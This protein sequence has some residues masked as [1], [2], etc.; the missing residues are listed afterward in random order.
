MVDKVPQPPRLTGDN[1]KDIVAIIDWLTAFAM[2]Q[3]TV[4]VENTNVDPTTQQVAAAGALM[5][6]NVI[7]EDNMASNSDTKVP[8]QQ[9]VKAYADAMAG[10]DA[11]SGIIQTPLDGTYL[12]VVKVPFGLTIVETVTKS[13][14]G[15]CTATFKIDGVA[16]GGTANAVS[17]AEQT[18]AQASANVAAAGTDISVTISAN[19]VCSGMSFTIKYSRVPG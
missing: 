10:I 12:L 8:T 1:G 17:S 11:I 18:Q 7:D 19:A 14:S 6:S 16:L 13:I 3:N 2:S 15:T 5:E 9:S 4:N